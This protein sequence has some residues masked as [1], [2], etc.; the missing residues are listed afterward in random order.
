[1]ASLSASNQ[2]II[3]NINVKCAMIIMERYLILMEIHIAKVSA[4]IK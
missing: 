3:L 4:F 1:M 2:T